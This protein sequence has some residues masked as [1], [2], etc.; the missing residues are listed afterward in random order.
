MA[1]TAHADALVCHAAE[2][3][4]FLQLAVSAVVARIAKASSKLTHAFALALRFSVS[5]E[6]AQVLLVGRCTVCASKAAS[7]EATAE[8]T[9][10]VT[11]AVVGTGQVVHKVLT[12]ITGE[13]G[14][15]VALAM[16]AEALVHTVTGTARFGFTVVTL[17]A[18]V[19]VAAVV[20][21]DAVR[22][23]AFTTARSN[24]AI[25][26]R[27][28]RCTEALASGMETRTLSTTFTT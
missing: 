15:A 21:T 22:G 4:R 11:S 7:A 26:S 2:R 20:L 27:L 5:G 25:I 28:P 8:L 23:T 9:H 1:L 3:T 14:V 10:P 18:W 19:T 17:V 6:H 24:G 13:A 12:C 16:H